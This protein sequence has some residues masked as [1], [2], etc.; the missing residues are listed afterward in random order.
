MYYIPFDELKTEGKTNIHRNKTKQNKNT[1]KTKAQKS[2]GLKF[3][4]RTRANLENK[5]TSK[6]GGE[7][8]RMNVYFKSYDFSFG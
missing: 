7:R 5:N 6:K 2:F 4:W 3:K 1:T 8:E